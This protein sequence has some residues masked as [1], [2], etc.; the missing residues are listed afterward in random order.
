MVKEIVIFMSLKRGVKYKYYFL[1]L[2]KQDTLAMTNVK[3]S[4]LLSQH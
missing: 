1:R 2:R 3:R 4:F